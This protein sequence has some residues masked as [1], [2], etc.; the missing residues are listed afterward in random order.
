MSRLE[1]RIDEI[2]FANNCKFTGNNDKFPPGK[3]N[4]DNYI[5]LKNPNDAYASA[6]NYLRNIKPKLLNSSERDFHFI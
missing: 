5:D 3:V 4:G 1:T 2:G 6:A